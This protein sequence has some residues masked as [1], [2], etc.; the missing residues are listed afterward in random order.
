MARSAKL[1][2]IDCIDALN[3]ARHLVAAAFMAASALHED[4]AEPIQTVLNAA[5]E[6]M[7]EAKAGL[8]SLRRLR[9]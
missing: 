3:E 2:L 4:E 1:D 5:T 6:K 8:S 7:Q 9:E